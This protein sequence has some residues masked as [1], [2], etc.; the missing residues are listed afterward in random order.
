MKTFSKIILASIALSQTA[1]T[2]ELLKEEPPA[3]LTIEEIKQNFSS[4]KPAGESGDIGS[5]S[6]IKVQEGQYHLNGSDANKL[7]QMYGNPPSRY[8][9]AIVALD[10]SYAITF[11]FSS[12]GYVKDDEKEELDADELLKAF[13]AADKEG[14]K[15]RLAAGLD[16]MTT[17]GWA[18]EPHYNENTNNLEWAVIYQSSDGSQTVNHNIKILGRKGVMN[19][20]LLCDPGQLENLRPMLDKTLAG[21]EYKPGNKYSEFQEGDK[22]ADYGLKGLLIGGGLLAAGKLG[23]FGLLAKYLKPIIGGIVAL[24]VGIVK[25]KDKIFKSKKS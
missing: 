13:K 17:I 23:L 21:F 16:S 11:N 22:I 7:M 8:D 20:T 6:M 9:G 4:A 5:N 3:P 2:Q 15:Q 10:D 14:N 25:F 12:E 19:A 18:F 24:G 1:F